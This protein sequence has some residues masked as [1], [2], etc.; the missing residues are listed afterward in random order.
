[1]NKIIISVVLAI[2]LSGCGISKEEKEWNQFKAD[3]ESEL[4]KGQIKHSDYYISIYNNTKH[5]SAPNKGMLLRHFVVMIDAS[6][7]FEDG[8]IEKR[9]FENIKRSA[10]TKLLIEK[11]EFDKGVVREQSQALLNLGQ[12]LERMGTPM[13]YRN[14]NT[15]MCPDGSYVSGTKCTLCPNGQYVAGRCSLMPNGQYIG[16]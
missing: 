15:A 13:K 12:Q 5:S 3:K 8:K 11:D 14:Q 6:Y 10:V 2:L 7:D 9:E 4:E 16:R 1:M